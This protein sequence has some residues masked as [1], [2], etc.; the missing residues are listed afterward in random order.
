MTIE[1]EFMQGLDTVFLTLA[2]PD[3]AVSVALLTT[4]KTVVSP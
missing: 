4:G 1:L 2:D 3:R